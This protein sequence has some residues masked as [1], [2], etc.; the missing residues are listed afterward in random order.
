M[1]RYSQ[2]EGLND[3]DI[4]EIIEKLFCENI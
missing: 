3:V 1:E 4:S 2:A